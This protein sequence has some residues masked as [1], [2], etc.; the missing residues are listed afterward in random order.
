MHLA[1]QSDLQ[2]HSRYNIFFLQY[3]GIE[4]TTFC[5]ADAM[6]HH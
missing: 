5:A 4:P 3:V 1:D 6:L 2:L